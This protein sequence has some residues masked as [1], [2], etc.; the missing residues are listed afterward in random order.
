MLDAEIKE[1]DAVLENL[2]RAQAPAL[3]EAPGVF[4]GTIAHMLVVLGDN[5]Q[6][7]R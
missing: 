1:H 6:R 4:T 5:P 2:V 3:M 7:I